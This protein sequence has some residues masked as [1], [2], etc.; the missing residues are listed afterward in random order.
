MNRQP[1]GAPQSCGGQFKGTDRSEADASLNGGSSL[2]TDP[3]SEVEAL[4][5]LDMVIE[6]AT[7]ASKALGVA[8][9]IWLG[10]IASQPAAKRVVRQVA[11]QLRISE[12]EARRTLDEVQGIAVRILEGQL[13]HSLAASL[14]PA[15]NEGHAH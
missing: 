3:V 4:A 10:S 1:E 11:E 7:Q 9:A 6:Q 13:G 5:V 8:S 12:D 15:D 14:G 2:A